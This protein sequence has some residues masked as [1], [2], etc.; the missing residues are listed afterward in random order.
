MIETYKIVSGKYDS[1]ITPTLALLD[2]RITRA[3]ICNFRSLVLNIHT[4]LT[5]RTSRMDRFF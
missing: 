1:E 3:T 4:G 2:A 5:P